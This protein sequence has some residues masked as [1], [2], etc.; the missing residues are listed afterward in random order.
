MTLNE[1]NVSHG[2]EQYK[3]MIRAA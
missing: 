1:E 3:N 2:Y